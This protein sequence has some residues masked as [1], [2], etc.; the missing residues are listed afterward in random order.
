M[1]LMGEIFTWWSGQTIGTRFHT[2]RHGEAVGEDDA[3]NKFY[4]SGDGER[5]WVIYNGEAEASRISPEWHG[6]LH[7]TF[8]QPPTD[9]PLPRKSWEQPHQPNLTGTGLEYRPPGS[10]THSAP[11]EARDYEAWVPE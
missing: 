7:K 8:D 5:R 11:K 6:W 1:G 10:I 9:D 2:W 4:Q 3:G